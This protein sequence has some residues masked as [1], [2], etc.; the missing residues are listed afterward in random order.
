MEGE[1]G[2]SERER[3]REE[4]KRGEKMEKE[5]ENKCGGRTEKQ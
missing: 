3:Q 1:R 2:E 5:D 4:G